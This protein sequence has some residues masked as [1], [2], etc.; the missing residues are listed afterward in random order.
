MGFT[1]VTFSTDWVRD[2]N[3]AM[4]LFMFPTGMIHLYA[5]IDFTSFIGA[6]F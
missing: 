1:S 5:S 6:C 3:C 4:I 2:F